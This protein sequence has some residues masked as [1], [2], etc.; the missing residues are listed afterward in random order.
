MQPNSSTPPP[1]GQ[2]FAPW[3]LGTMAVVLV[4]LLVVSIGFRMALSSPTARAVAA[5]APAR[6]SAWPKPSAKASPSPSP[7]PTIEPTAVPEPTAEPTPAP[8]PTAVPPTPEPTAD[9]ELVAAR[10]YYT[11]VQQILTP[12]RMPSMGQVTTR[13]GFPRIRRCTSTQSGVSGSPRI[14]RHCRRPGQPD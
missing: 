14:C 9:P 1:A 6:S 7:E 4:L 5:A 13:V 3:V 11:E 2:N 10:A 8:E 12:W